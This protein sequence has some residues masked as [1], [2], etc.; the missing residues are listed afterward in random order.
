MKVKELIAM[1]NERDPEAIVLISG[2]ETIGGTEVAEADVLVEMQS[3]CLDKA[4]NLTGNRKVVPSGGEVSV[5]EGA[6]KRG[7][8]SRLTQSF[9]FFMF[10]PI[11]SPVNAL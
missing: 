4:D 5:W 11:F 2:Y 8:S 1:L 10:E 6:N 7:N 9:H 3:I